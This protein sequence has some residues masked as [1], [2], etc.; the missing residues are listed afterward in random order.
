MEAIGERV[1]LQRA[2][3]QAQLAGPNWGAGGGAPAPAE[4]QYRISHF[5]WTGRLETL[6]VARF[7]LISSYYYCI[8]I[9]SLHNWE[10]SGLE[11]LDSTVLRRSRQRLARPCM[12]QPPVTFL[13]IQFDLNLIIN[14]FPLL[15]PAWE[16]QLT[17]LPV[18]TLS[19]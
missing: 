11:S 17:F 16:Y 19:T 10:V 18:L 9:A 13:E 15:P 1:A 6:I 3:A 14:L 4:G 12:P 5:Q 7:W 8:F 2:N